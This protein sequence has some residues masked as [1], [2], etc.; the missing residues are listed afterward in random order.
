MAFFLFPLL[1]FIVFATWQFV[2][3]PHFALS[4]ILIA[5]VFSA[6]LYEQPIEL[7]VSIYAHDIVFI[8]LFICALYRVF[9]KGELA[10]ISILWIIYGL[11]LFYQVFIGITTYGTPAAADFRTCFYYW[12]GGIYF[13]SFQYTEAT[14]NR[15]IKYWLNTCLILLALVYFRLAADVANLPMAQAWR[16]MDAGDIRFRVI[17]GQH[18]YLLGVAVVMLFHKYLVNNET[19]PSKIITALFIIAVIV[20]QHRSVWMATFVAMISSLA[21][22]SIKKTKV[23]NNLIIISIMGIILLIPVVYMG[24]ADKIIS[25]IF[26]SAERATSLTTGTFGARVSGW[27]T[28]LYYF[29]HQN[30]LHQLLGDPFGS[31]YARSKI[32]PHNFYFQALLRVGVLG[33]FV[34]LL[35]YLITMAKLF[36]KLAKKDD[37]NIY[38]SLFLMLMIG[39]QTFYVPYGQQAEHG[40]IL[41]I[42]ISL[43]KRKKLLSNLNNTKSQSQYFINTTPRLEK[44]VNKT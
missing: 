33:T 42:A 8:P 27:K 34:L 32:V 26:L 4:G 37:T 5:S 3:K 39:Q 11:L 6:L 17:N 1:L 18:T 35:T 43:A 44:D 2:G 13:M 19:K 12:T 40:I 10:S 14:L 31:G 15:L 16:S 30:F 22:P 29:S 24:Y 9:L 36:I 20:L 38:L 25:N 23:I 7:G 41:G 28:I 21:L